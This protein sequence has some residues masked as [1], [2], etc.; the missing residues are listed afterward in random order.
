MARRPFDP[1]RPDPAQV[2]AESA[3]LYEMLFVDLLKLAQSQR[4]TGLPLLPFEATGAA[5]NLDRMIALLGVMAGCCEIA[6]FSR[7]RDEAGAHQ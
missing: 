2:W 4:G 1:E 3:R 7:P 5:Q 6:W